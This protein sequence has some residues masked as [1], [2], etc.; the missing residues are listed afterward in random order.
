MTEPRTPPTRENLIVRFQLTS[1][2]LKDPRIKRLLFHKLALDTEIFHVRQAFFASIHASKAQ[3][4]ETAARFGFTPAD[5]QKF[6][7]VQHGLHSLTDSLVYLA[8][9]NS[10]VKSRKPVTAPATKP[11][12]Q[13][14]Y[15][16]ESN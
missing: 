11:P 12:L 6:P 2:P 4:E 14:K 13:P 5:I 16:E 10:A 15:P 1:E 7:H 8:N 3:V 9:L